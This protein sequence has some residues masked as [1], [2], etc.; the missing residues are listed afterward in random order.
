MRY[1]T[2]EFDMRFAHIDYVKAYWLTAS[3]FHV[4]PLPGRFGMM[5]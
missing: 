2:D 4:M 5:T 3:S 1:I